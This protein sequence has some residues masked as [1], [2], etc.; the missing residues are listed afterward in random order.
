MA[1]RRIDAVDIV[2]GSG[3]HVLNQQ[4]SAEERAQLATTQP[5]QTWD[6]HLILSRQLP[7]NARYLRLFDLGLQQLKDSG[8]YRQIWQQ[9]EQPAPLKTAP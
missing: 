9:F 4:L 7:D 1:A 6:Y 3:S 5:Y 8:R 2:K